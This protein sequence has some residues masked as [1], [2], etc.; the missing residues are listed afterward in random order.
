M[1]QVKTRWLDGP[2]RYNENGELLVEDEP[3]V[4]IPAFR[5]G[6]QQGERVRPVG[7]IERSSTHDATLIASPINLPS[8]DRAAHMCSLP[9]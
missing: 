8:W 5:I 2:R 7:D 6:A 3:V 1:G 4:A 9:F